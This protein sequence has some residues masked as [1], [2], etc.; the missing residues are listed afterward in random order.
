MKYFV[1]PIIE[2]SSFYRT[3]KAAACTGKDRKTLKF[4]AQSQDV[5]PSRVTS[6]R[7]YPNP[8][9]VREMGLSSYA[10]SYQPSMI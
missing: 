5:T 10:E 3:H 1:M 2:D 8:E 4:C 9:I 6:R 7:N